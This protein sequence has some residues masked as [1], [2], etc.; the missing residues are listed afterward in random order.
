MKAG[1]DQSLDLQKPS[2]L[3]K[4]TVVLKHHHQ[5]NFGREGFI[6][7]MLP[8]HCSSLKEVRTGTQTG[9]AP[10]GRS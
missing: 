5:S 6:W 4:V 1:E 3:V 7:L 9:Q 10:E 8:H 2:V